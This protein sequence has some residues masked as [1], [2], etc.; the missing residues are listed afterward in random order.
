M[1]NI[2]LTFLLS[3]G[4]IFCKAQT[5]NLVIFS[6]NGE[7]FNIALNGVVQNSEPKSNIKVTDLNAEYMS[8]RVAFSNPELGEITK[9]LMLEK[10]NEVTYIIKKNKKGEYVLR[11]YSSNPVA[12]ATETSGQDVVVYHSTPLPEKAETTSTT[13]TTVTTTTETNETNVANDASSNIS[14]KASGDGENVNVN[15]NASESG[16]MNF[17]ASDGENSVNV[18]IDMSGMAGNMDVEETSTSTTTT[19]TTTNTTV[20]ETAVSTSEPV[21]NHNTGCLSP[22]TTSEYGRGIQSI[23]ARSFD[24]EKMIVAK[25]V[26]RNNCLSTEQVRGIMKTFDFDK[27]KLSIAKYAYDYT[28]DQ[29]NYYT[30]NDEFTFDDEVKSLNAFLKTKGR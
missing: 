24:D 20:E 12:S 30:L 2:Y 19:T 13:T 17:S 11:G 4:A 5:S 29:K 25:Q 28:S 8:A 16:K 14:M 3:A 7:L 22:M 27:D 6:Q 1:K 18:N 15:M 21:V 9:N 10:G 26:I 23:K